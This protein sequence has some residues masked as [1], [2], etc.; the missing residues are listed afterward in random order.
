MNVFTGTGAFNDPMAGFTADIARRKAAKRLEVAAGVGRTML[1]DVLHLVNRFVDAGSGSRIAYQLPQTELQKLQ[2]R[3]VI[4]V[5]HS[6]VHELEARGFRVSRVGPSIVPH[7]LVVDWTTAP[8]AVEPVKLTGPAFPDAVS[9]AT[10]SRPPPG[11]YSYDDPT[12]PPLKVDLIPIP[13]LKPGAGKTGRRTDPLLVEVSERSKKPDKPKTP[14]K[15]RK[16]KQST[17]VL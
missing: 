16:P 7:T 14:R 3:A 13:P 12:A 5:V 2:G 10:Q 15:P 17:L 8:G 9:M 6:L 1:L 4:D 11:V